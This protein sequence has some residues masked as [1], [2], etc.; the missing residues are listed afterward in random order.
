M[1]LRTG[2]LIGPENLNIWCKLPLLYPC[3]WVRKVISNHAKVNS[4][5][6]VRNSFLVMIITDS[7]PTFCVEIN[8]AGL[9]AINLPK[10][11]F[12]VHLH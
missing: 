11:T 3:A 8:S 2:R 7:R 9:I 12:R 1:D 6:K 10:N 5:K 4:S